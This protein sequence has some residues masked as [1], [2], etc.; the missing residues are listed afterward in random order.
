MHAIFFGLYEKELPAI[1]FV[2]ANVEVGA[3]LRHD[4]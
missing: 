1:L 3:V 4:L 2:T